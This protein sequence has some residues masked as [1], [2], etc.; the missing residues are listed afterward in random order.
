[1]EGDKDDLGGV[2]ELLATNVYSYVGRSLWKKIR[3]TS[4]VWNKLR[5]LSALWKEPLATNLDSYVGG[6]L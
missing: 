2:G 5:M 3:T 4:E 1:V 6:S